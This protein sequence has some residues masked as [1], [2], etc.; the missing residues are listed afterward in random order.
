MDVVRRYGLRR[1]KEL[2]GSIQFAPSPVDD[3]DR[4][5]TARRIGKWKSPNLVVFS[6][7]RIVTRILRQKRN[8]MVNQGPCNLDSRAGN[9]II[10]R[11]PP[12]ATHS[13]HFA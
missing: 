9:R 10:E 5:S 4:E 11:P 2:P 6:N 8:A 1:H 7:C 12:I 3:C 13:G